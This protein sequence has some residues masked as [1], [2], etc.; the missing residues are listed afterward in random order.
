MVAVEKQLT[1]DEFWE[2]Y[3]G[4]RVELV[5]GEPV[6][7]TPTSHKHG[8]IVSRMTIYLGNYVI[9][10]DLGELLGAETGFL[11]RQDPDVLRA[12]DIAFIAKERLADIEDPYKFTP[13]P[14][15]LAIEVVSPYDRAGDVQAKVSDYLEAGVRLMWIIYPQQKQVVVHRPDGTSETLG[16][17][18][19]LT[20]GDVLPG[21]ALPLARLFPPE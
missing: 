13:F 9:E 6:E 14:P 10:H 4:Q 16:A 11:L 17:A 21:F 20:G 12:A 5:R 3:A 7:M 15:D 1:A 18:D 8:V 19:T 2:K